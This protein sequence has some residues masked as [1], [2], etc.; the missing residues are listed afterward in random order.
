VERG[1][2]AQRRVEFGKKG[3]QVELPRKQAASEVTHDAGLDVIGQDS[4]IDQ[5]RTRRFENDVAEGLP[6]LA[7]VPLE[8]RA[9]GAK[10]INNFGHKL[11]AA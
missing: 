9:P 6:F 5:R 4:C 1:Q 2:A 11:N 7:E 10:D 3:A 8:I